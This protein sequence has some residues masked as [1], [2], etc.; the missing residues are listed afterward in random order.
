M[1]I[2][3]Q[4][5]PHICLNLAMAILEYAHNEAKKAAVSAAKADIVRREAE[6]LLLEVKKLRGEI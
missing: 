6:E 4:V 2:L 5:K 3:R 1:T